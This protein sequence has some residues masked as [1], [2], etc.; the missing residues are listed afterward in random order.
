MGRK[1]VDYKDYSGE[2]VKAFNES[3][4]LLVGTNNEGLNNVM[5]SGWGMVG[6]IWGRPILMVMVRPSRF[7]YKFIEE[8]GQFTANVVPPGLKEAVEYCGTVSGRDHNKFEEKRLTPIPSLK[9]KPP[10]IQEC[11]LHFE[12]QVVYKS[13]LA[14]V[15]M[16]EAFLSQFY[17]QRNF[18]RLYFGEILACQSSA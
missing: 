17:P 10:I 5:A 6:F 7:T 16:E 11:I 14:G 18:H 9:V 2:M 4:V 1:V 3:R 13:D 15:E 12:C 8:T